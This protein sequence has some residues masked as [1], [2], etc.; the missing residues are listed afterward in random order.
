MRTILPL[1]MPTL[2]TASRPVSGSM[3]RPPSR[4]RSYCWAA[5]IV[6]EQKR[7]KRERIRRRI[8]PRTRLAQDLEIISARLGDVGG[9]CVPRPSAGGY[10]LNRDRNKL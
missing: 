6:V 5:T 10:A 7:K 9:E 8:I 1:R 2:R 4:T 3:T